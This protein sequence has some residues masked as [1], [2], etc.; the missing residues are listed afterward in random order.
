MCERIK[1]ANFGPIREV[2][3]EDIRPLTVFI[4]E[5]GSGKSTIMKV[6][7][8][9]RWMFKRINIRSFL[10]NAG[11]T[12]LKELH[13]DM[14]EL[15]KYS[16][17]DEYL[18]SDTEIIYENE[19][20]RIS[21]ANGRLNT[22]KKPID[23]ESLSLN[24]IC[25]ISDKR[26]EIADVL[27]GNIRIESSGSYFQE[28]LA[29]FKL[30]AGDMDSFS[31]DYLGVQLKK[32]KDQKKERYV[33]TGLD[34]DAD[35]SVSL[36]NASSGIQTVSP[37]ALIVQYYA[38]RYNSVEGMNKTIF[39][40]LADND[41]LKN[42]KSDM[43]VGDIRSSHIFIHIEEPELSLYP[44]S[45]KSLI[46]FLVNKCFLTE[47]SDKMSIVM[48]THS[49]YIVN[50]LNLLIRRAE[51]KQPLTEAQIG[52]ND[53]D[54]YEVVD[55][56]IISLKIKKPSQVVDVSSLSEPISN[57]YRQY[58]LLE[59]NDAALSSKKSL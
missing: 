19:G 47:H 14:K 7:S 28:T 45:Q 23:K 26:N 53:V 40:F 27:T 41:D 49:P 16:G 35:F 56:Q 24:K 54:V 3:I 50:Y 22:P 43:N 6:L 58:N 25:F 5:S 36:E 8:L 57:I 39:K 48:A 30:A 51:T 29:D 2:E 37:L 15:L 32:I 55:G 52:F 44:E 42:F 10:R 17:I 9:F 13:F 11:A 31:I 1:I 12:D 46:D 38:T 21:Y 59:N 33:I 4:G 34:D 20:Y 18:K